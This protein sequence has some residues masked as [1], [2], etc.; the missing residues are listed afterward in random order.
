[1]PGAVWAEPDLAAGAAAL[2]DLAGDAARRRKIG[3]AAKAAI[4]ERL[5]TRPCRLALG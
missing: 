4:A 1:M 3:A 5:A 2:A